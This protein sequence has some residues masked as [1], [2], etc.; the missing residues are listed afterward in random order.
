MTNEERVLNQFLRKDVDYLPSQITFSDRSRDKQIAEGLGIDAVDLDAYLQNHIAFTFN[1]D[2]I[3]LFFHNDDETMKWLEPAGHCKMDWE[4]D[5]C[6]DNWGTGIIRHQDGFFT[7]FG[8]MDWDDEKKKKAAPFLPERLQGITEMSLEKACEFYTAP[9]PMVEGNFEW[10][11]RDKKELSGDF[12]VIPSGYFGIYERAYS[13]LGWEQYMTEVAG[14]PKMI[15]GLMEKITDYRIKT[16]KAKEDA[17]F[18]IAHI[19]DD[20]GTQCRGFFSPKMFKEV[21]LPH[22]KRL[23]AEHKKYGHFIL[24]H[25]CGH[26]MDYLPELIDIGLDGWEPVQPCNDLKTIKREYGKD[27]VFWGGI[28]TQSLPLMKPDQV[29]EMA[30]EAIKILGKGGGYVIAPSQE[31]MADVPIENIIA[32]VE[33]IKELRDKVM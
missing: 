8:P 7:D 13:L 14:N 16:A 17:G 12:M 11:Y 3:P 20:L 22:Y 9:D 10:Y 28:D 30:T 1:K 26:V 18:K 21:V 4:N 24:M 31:L 29:K 5:I 27:L 6:Y 2:D 25:S 15:Y 33:T 32:I 19:G 23:F